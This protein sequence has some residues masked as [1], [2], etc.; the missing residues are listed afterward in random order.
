MRKIT[1]VTVFF[2]ITVAAATAE[3]RLPFSTVFKGRDKFDRLV[4]SAREG[5]W[6]ALPD[7]RTDGDGRPG[8]GRHAV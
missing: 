3:S 1:L 6:S 7:R 2:I 8:H 5:N 4:N